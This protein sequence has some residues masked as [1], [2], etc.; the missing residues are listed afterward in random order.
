MH[1]SAV[2]GSQK[3]EG[4]V[5]DWWVTLRFCITGDSDVRT[6]PHCTAELPEGREPGDVCVKSKEE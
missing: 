4:K 2:L 5:E 6:K 3:T 1:K